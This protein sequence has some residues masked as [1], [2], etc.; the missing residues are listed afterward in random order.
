MAT[1]MEPEKAARLVL[2]IIVNH[3]RVRVDGVLGANNVMFVWTGK[4]LKMQDMMAGFE[5]A[6]ESGWVL[7]DPSRGIVLTQA[8]HDEA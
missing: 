3:F 4:Q 6:I 8:G 7:D 2:D 5:Y 1:A